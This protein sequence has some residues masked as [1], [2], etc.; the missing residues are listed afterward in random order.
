MPQPADNIRSTQGASAHPR[1]SSKS[2]WIVTVAIVFMV[3]LSVGFA[4]R[5]AIVPPADDSW[6][7]T[8]R[9]GWSNMYTTMSGDANRSEIEYFVYHPDVDRDFVAKYVTGHDLIKDVVGTLYDSASVLVIDR[10]NRSILSE[11]ESEPWAQFA[12][13]GELMFFCH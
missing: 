5:L 9:D 10:K 13:R 6:L 11:I 12:I 1:K 2:L 4:Q 8:V 3:G 7:G